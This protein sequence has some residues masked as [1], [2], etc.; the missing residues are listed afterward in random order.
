MAATLKTFAGLSV[1][2]VICSVF[3]FT[4]MYLSKSSIIPSGQDFVSRV[5]QVLEFGFQLRLMRAYTCL[6]LISV[7]RTFI[8]GSTACVLFFICSIN[9]MRLALD[10]LICFIVYL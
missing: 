8:S 1:Q 3:Y 10:L 5:N 2:T 6:T 9:E 4:S 7:L